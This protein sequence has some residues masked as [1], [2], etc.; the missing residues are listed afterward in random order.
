MQF[1]CSLSLQGLESLLSDKELPGPT[2]ARP[3]LLTGRSGP[4]PQNGAAMRQSSL[5]VGE[6]QA[7]VSEFGAPA[8][9]PFMSAQSLN[10]V[11]KNAKLGSAW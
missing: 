7:L 4:S 6:E 5:S 1:S 10:G 9:I 3:F 11:F 8:N 2:S